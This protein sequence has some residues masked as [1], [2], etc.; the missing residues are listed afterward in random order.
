M[1][2]MARRALVA[3]DGMVSR[4]LAARYLGRSVAIVLVLLWLLVEIWPSVRHSTQVFRGRDLL[5]SWMED[6][7]SVDPTPVSFAALTRRSLGGKAPTSRTKA[8]GAG[9]DALTRGSGTN[10][11][12]CRS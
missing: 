3:I 8:G 7:T 4:S 9:A 1:L 11:A 2:R 5:L 6:C 10:R 12:M